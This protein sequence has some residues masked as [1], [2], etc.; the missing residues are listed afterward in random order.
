MQVYQGKTGHYRCHNKYYGRRLSTEGVEQTLY[1]FLHNGYN[2]RT[3][4]V[5]PIVDRLR[6]LHAM[7]SK[8]N[9]FRFYSSSLLIMYEGGE[10]ESA[11]MEDDEDSSNIYNEMSDEA[12]DLET[13]E[14]E[15]DSLGPMEPDH[16][17][18][19]TLL[20]GHSS[21]SCSSHPSKY[22]PKDLPPSASSHVD[23][24]MIDFAHATH[25]GFRGDRTV[26]S[27][28]D[29]GYLFGLENLIRM[30]ERLKERCTVN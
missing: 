22:S 20:P 11:M 15:E 10:P 5:A 30:F 18:D 17:V 4:L 1:E 12:C 26:H 6:R 13:E 24:R 2:V 7:L 8:Q 27:G 21:A 25:Q 16:Q 19:A 9:A 23:A 28:P 3:E 14:E 29:K